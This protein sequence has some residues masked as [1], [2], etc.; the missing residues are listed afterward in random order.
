MS[1]FRQNWTTH[2]KH[3][4]HD[5]GRTIH[6]VVAGGSATMPRSKLRKTVKPSLLGP[7]VA[8]PG[9]EPIEK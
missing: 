3:N 1:S 9:K 2:L 7:V 6:G 5:L 8:D 4:R